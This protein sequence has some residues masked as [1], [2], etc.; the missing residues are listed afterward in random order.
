MGIGMG[1]GMGMGMGA[2]A[3]RKTALSKERFDR[4][5]DVF[6][7]QAFGFARHNESSSPGES[8]PEALSEPDVKLSPHTAPTVQPPV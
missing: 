5:P 8:H 7:Q 3:W 1:I 2:A 6:F 4:G